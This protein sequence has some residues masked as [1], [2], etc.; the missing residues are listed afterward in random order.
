MLVDSHCHLDFPNLSQDLDDVVA[1]ASR[2]GVQRMVTISTR[3]RQMQA[4]LDIVERY[5]TVY[6]SV[7]T[8]P[9]YADEDRDIPVSHIV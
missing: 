6:G 7:G 8:R 3:I 4:V 1:R 9:H 2:A 5:E